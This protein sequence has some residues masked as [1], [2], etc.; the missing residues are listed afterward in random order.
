MVLIKNFI[1]QNFSSFFF[2]NTTILPLIVYEDTFL[3]NTLKFYF[4][5]IL[6]FVLKVNIY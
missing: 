6:S 2:D 5:F 4:I 3:L 1:L